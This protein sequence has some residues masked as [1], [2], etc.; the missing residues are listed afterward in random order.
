MALTGGDRRSG[1]RWA[2]FRAG[3]LAREPLCRECRRAGYT[4]GAEEVD[5]VEPIHRGGAVF[6]LDNVQPLCRRCHARKTAREGGYVALE[7]RDEW[8]DHLRSMG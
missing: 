5:H 7:T 1:R 3:V 6:D 4:V 8:D 2:R